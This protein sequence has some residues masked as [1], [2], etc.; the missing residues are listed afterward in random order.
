MSA[1][2][3]AARL[4]AAGFLVALATGCGDAN[5]VAVHGKVTLDGQPYTAV[6]IMPKGFSFPPPMTF[7]SNEL[8]KGCEVWLPLVLDRS[9]RDY[10][11]LAGV[12]RLKRG[13]KIEQARAE[14]AGLAR[15][16]AQEHAKSNAGIGGTISPM[17]EQVV[18]S[19][20]PALRINSRCTSPG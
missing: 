20:R 9:N 16:L 4:A 3:R 13:V 15:R 7:M 5:R 6:G 18:E 17:S 11:P 8:P 10:H 1:M 2:R 14:V 12:A 19:V